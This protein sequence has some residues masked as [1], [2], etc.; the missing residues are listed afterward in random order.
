MSEPRTELD[1]RFSDPDTEPTSWR[2]AVEA[3]ESAQLAW[4]TTVRSD[5]RPHVTPLVAIWHDDA[6]YFTTGPTEQK[7]VNLHHSPAVAITT[8]CNDWD[9]GLDV[10][11]EGNARRITDQPTLDALAT[12]WATKWDGRWQFRVDP[13]GFRHDG[14]DDEHGIAHVYEVQPTKVLAFGKRPFTHTRHL[15]TPPVSP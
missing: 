8:G 1:P 9:H 7:A 6:C 2:A 5:G 10:V 3:L 13:E 4:I 14:D 15:P 11:V 12:A